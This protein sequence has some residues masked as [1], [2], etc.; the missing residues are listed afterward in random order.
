M[1]RS[2]PRAYSTPKRESQTV[3]L[4]WRWLPRR[5]S[6]RFLS[7]GPDVAA[8]RS[9]YANR[10]AFMPAASAQPT[11]RRARP[12]GAPFSRKLSP[13]IGTNGSPSL[14]FSPDER[15]RIAPFL[16]RPAAAPVETARRR[17]KSRGKKCGGSVVGRARHFRDQLSVFRDFHHRH[18]QLVVAWIDVRRAGVSGLAL[19]ACGAVRQ[20][21]DPQTAPQFRS[22]RLAPDAARAEHPYRDCHNRDGCR[23]R[24]TRFVRRRAR[25][26]LADCDSD[27]SGGGRDPGL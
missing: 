10:S 9:S 25:R 8:T 11:S 22:F 1:S 19:L 27:E 15:K 17:R 16:F 14:R 21:I 4:F 7:R 13:A 24:A 18:C 6:I 20:F 3:H 12:N 23:T 26:D 5:R 2:P